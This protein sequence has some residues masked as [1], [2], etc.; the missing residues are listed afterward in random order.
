MELWNTGVLRA[1]GLEPGAWSNEQ[2]GKQE[3]EP[4][5][6]LRETSIDISKND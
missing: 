1:K 3:Q 5:V 2:R 4:E 6:E